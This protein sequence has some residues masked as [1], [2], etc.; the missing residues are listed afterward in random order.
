VI[1]SDAA[2]VM[3]TL[4]GQEAKTSPRLY[5]LT[6]GV[7]DY[8]DSGLRL[9]FAVPDAQVIGGAR[10]KRGKGLYERVEVTIAL[11]G[12]ATATQLD[13]TFAE[14]SQKVRQ[15]DVFVFF[16]SGHVIEVTELASFVDRNVPELSNNA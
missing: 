2:Q 15:Q 9:A 14:R 1:A 5:V 12:Q 7:N 8:W 10:S 11:D 3:I 13:R 6:V 4:Q 16:L